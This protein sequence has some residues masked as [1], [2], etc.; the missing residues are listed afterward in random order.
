MENDQYFKYLRTKIDEEIQKVIEVYSNNLKNLSIISGVIAP[1]SLTLLGIENLQIQKYFLLLGFTLLVAN[2][3]INQLFL[4][5]KSK[6]YDKKSLDAD[7]KWILN[8][9]LAITD[10]IEKAKKNIER[11]IAGGE[12]EKD[13]D[14]G[15]YKFNIQKYRSD[16]R[17]YTQISS[18]IFTS[19]VIFTVLS[20]WFYPI[21]NLF[22]DNKIQLIFK[23][24]HI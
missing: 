4:N 16:F 14:L 18:V 6:E 17:K 15:E 5:R 21:L 2:I 11:Y 19:G 20:I 13:L 3:L 23:C 10:P 12:I 1:L 9:D 24:F 7:I 22:G 8:S